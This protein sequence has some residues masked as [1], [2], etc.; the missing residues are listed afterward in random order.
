MPDPLEER[1]Q[2]W[3]NRA[4]RQPDEHVAARQDRL[5]AA[6]RDTFSYLVR[7]FRSHELARC[8]TD[9]VPRPF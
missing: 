9:S 1:R 3:D 7:G 8:R 5:F 6:E 2:P 4:S